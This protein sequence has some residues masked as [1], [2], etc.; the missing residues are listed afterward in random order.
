MP[1]GFRKEMKAV[2]PAPSK[3][4]KHFGEENRVMGYEKLIW[5][6]KEGAG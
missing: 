5:N 1:K 3:I 6:R 2:N 4:F